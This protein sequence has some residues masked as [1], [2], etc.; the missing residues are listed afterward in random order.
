MTHYDVQTNDEGRFVINTDDL[1]KDIYDMNINF[2]GHDVYY[3]DSVR[4]KITLVNLPNSIELTATEQHIYKNRSSIIS[5]T[6]KDVNENVIINEPIY[7]YVNNKLVSS[8]KTDVNGVAQYIYIGKGVGEVNIKAKAK[9][10]EESILII[11]DLIIKSITINAPN[12]VTTGDRVEII[13]SVIDLDDNIA[14][15][16]EVNFYD[17]DDT[18]LNPT[19]IITNAEGKAIFEYIGEGNN[20]YNNIKAV[21]GEIESSYL[22]ILDMAKPTHINISKIEPNSNYAKNKQTSLISIYIQDFLHR[23]VP[24]CPIEFYTSETHSQY[25]KKS[26]NQSGLVIFEYIG[27]GV[28]DITF[29]SSTAIENFDNIE[30]TQKITEYMFYDECNDN[31]GISN[32]SIPSIVNKTPIT[33]DCEENDHY[34]IS[35]SDDGFGVIEIKNLKPTDFILEADFYSLNS[36]YGFSLLLD[37]KTTYCY[38]FSKDD[39]YI[40][41]E[42]FFDLLGNLCSFPLFRTKIQKNQNS[43]LGENNWTHVTLTKI[44]DN[45]TIEFYEDDLNIFTES[46]TNTNDV[47]LGIC[48]KSKNGDE[49]KVKNISVL[50]LNKTKLKNPS[51][52]IL[53]CNNNTISPNYK[54]STVLTATVLD[55]EGNP[56]NHASVSFYQNDKKIGTGLTDKNGIAKKTYYSNGVGDVNF[57]AKTQNIKSNDLIISDCIKYD[58]AST[59]RSNEY[60]A[61][62]QELL[63]FNGYYFI[64]YQQSNEFQLFEEADNVEVSLEFQIYTDADT[65]F[66]FGYKNNINEAYLKITSFGD[67]AVQKNNSIVGQT[68]STTIYRQKSN[69]FAWNYYTLKIK[70]QDG[71]MEFSIENQNGVQLGYDY[72]AI[73]RE[74]GKFFLRVTK[75]VNCKIKNIKIKKTNTTN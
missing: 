30:V 55:I 17:I 38:F 63:F 26:T 68:E 36:D 20:L 27:Q 33:L 14:P 23:G 19:P 44:D 73:I 39:S 65:E 49:V 18:L 21:S 71:M 46:F 54:D 57:Y 16:K 75:Y 41:G 6:V 34:S 53:N 28:G 25:Q 69:E 67:V 8:T 43:V 5:A 29:S 61:S 59:D 72:K 37:K 3:D 13:A 22:T 66:C 12:I 50:E 35:K 64:S 2:D 48:V 51:N 42:I 4:K 10:I 58:D 60:P 74:I 70:K 1:E 15:N 31:K 9:N 40:Y 56:I 52:V 32:Y 62:F 45:Y 11:D 7:F 47:S 24:N